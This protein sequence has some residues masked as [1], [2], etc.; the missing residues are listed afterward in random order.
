MNAQDPI[1]A[2]ASAGSNG[3]QGRSMAEFWAR[4]AAALATVVSVG[5]LAWAGVMWSSVVEMG[6]LATTVATMAVVIQEVQGTLAEMRK[7]HRESMM[8]L[9]SEGREHSGRSWH[10]EAGNRLNTVDL[11]I[12][13]LIKA[14]ADTQRYVDQQWARIRAHGENIEILRHAIEALCSRAGSDCGV[15]LSEPDRF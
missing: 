15:V 12:Q 14:S 6:K 8:H 10:E 11:Q 9:R 2:K 4:F 3:K 1:A 7:E 13:Q 5:F